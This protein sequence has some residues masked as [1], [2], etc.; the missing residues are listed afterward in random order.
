MATTEIS[1]SSLKDNSEDLFANKQL[2]QE[3]DRQTLGMMSDIP[4]NNYDLFPNIAFK[5]E[6]QKDGEDLFE[7]KMKDDG[8][9]LSRSRNR[10]RS[11]SNFESSRKDYRRRERPVYRS[12]NGSYSKEIRQYIEK[13]SQ[14]ENLREQGNRRIEYDDDGKWAKNDETSLESRLDFHSKK[15]WHSSS[16]GNNDDDFGARLGRTNEG[17]EKKKGK[18]RPRARDHF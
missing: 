17:G 9:R 14:S 1:S 8:L 15:Q 3:R 18:R 10:S 11:P 5:S 7:S 2:S 16:K 6:E 4:E 12:R 13:D